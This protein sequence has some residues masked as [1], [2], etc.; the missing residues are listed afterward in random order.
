MDFLIPDKEPKLKPCPFCGA[1]LIRCYDKKEYPSGWY[2]PQTYDCVLGAV[3]RDDMPLY[4][5]PGQEEMWN[6]RTP[7]E[8]TGTN[9][10]AN[11]N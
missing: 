10:M 2:H 4:V 1:E 7:K 11:S 3:D 9:E 5:A 8:R 6:T